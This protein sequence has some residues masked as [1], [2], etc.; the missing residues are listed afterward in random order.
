MASA[1]FEVSRTEAISSAKVN[2]ESSLRSQFC[3]FPEEPFS[4]KIGESVLRL[5]MAEVWLRPK[6]AWRSI[7][8]HSWG[9]NWSIFRGALF[10]ENWWVMPLSQQWGQWGQNQLGG[11]KWV[12]AEV[13]VWSISRGALFHSKLVSY[14]FESLLWLVVEDKTIAEVN[15]KSSLRSHYTESATD[16]VGLF[17]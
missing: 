11:H 16:S 8:S 14:A 15:S 5:G 7:L 17:S 6:P 9:H 13:T 12:I 4:Q 10:S 1:S 2:S 3:L